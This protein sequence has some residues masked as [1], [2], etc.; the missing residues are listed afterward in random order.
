MVL[1]QQMVFPGDKGPQ[2]FASTE[3]NWRF[4]IC[5]VKFKSR[6][7]GVQPWAVLKGDGPNSL[8]IGGSF[9]PVQEGNPNSHSLP[10]I[11]TNSLFWPCFMSH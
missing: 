10:F 5:I 6:A 11:C 9:L 3:K 7:P 2:S 1:K 8:A 4:N